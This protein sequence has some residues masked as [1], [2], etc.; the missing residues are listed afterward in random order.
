MNQFIP[1]LA[2]A[3]VASVLTAFCAFSQQVRPMA[4]LF[5]SSISLLFFASLG[6]V[7]TLWV[8]R[9]FKS[10]IANSEEIK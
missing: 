7:L 10:L 9:T 6:L 4:I 2:L 3:A 5:R 8:K 1:A